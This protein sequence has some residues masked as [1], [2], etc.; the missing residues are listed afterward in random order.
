MSIASVCNR[1]AVAIRR[2]ESVTEAA[3]QMRNHHVGSLVIVEDNDLGEK[4][5]VGIITDR[6]ITVSVTALALDPS[7]ITVNEVMGESVVCVNEN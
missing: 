5:P 6:D 7:V 2:S 3:R 4:I 1:N